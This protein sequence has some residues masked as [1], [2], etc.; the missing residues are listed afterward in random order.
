MF[1]VDAIVIVKQ[2]YKKACIIVVCI[3][4]SYDTLTGYYTY[5][6]IFWNP[7]GIE[8]TK[9]SWKGTMISC[10]INLII[11]LLKPILSDIGRYLIIKICANR[12]MVDFDSKNTN[13][14]GNNSSNTSDQMNISLT[15]NVRSYLLY[16]KAR[17]EWKRPE[18]EQPT[19][20]GSNNASIQILDPYF[21]R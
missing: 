13:D 5:N 11:F 8:Q 14:D 7:F 18:F 16:K 3:I 1:L 20:V 6:D 17:I 2:K 19:F 10:V 15:K 4:A 9:I 12:T 21:S